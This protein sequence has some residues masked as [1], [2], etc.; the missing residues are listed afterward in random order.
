MYFDVVGA[1]RG[2]REVKVKV[3]WKRC[4]QTRRRK[5]ARDERGKIK[6]QS[7][8]AGL[9]YNLRRLRESFTRDLAMV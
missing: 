3:K 2:A 7:L 4:R 5:N 8:E 6:V 1:D 9:W